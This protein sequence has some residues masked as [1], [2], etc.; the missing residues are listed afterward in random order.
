MNKCV[1]HW[2]IDRDGYGV[3]QNCGKEKKFIVYI[4]DMMRR[5]M[6]RNP[7]EMKRARAQRLNAIFQS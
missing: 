6:S 2:H 4:D 1:H 3:C 7:E 5:Y